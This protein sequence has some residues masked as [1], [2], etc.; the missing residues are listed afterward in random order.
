MSD[1]RAVARTLLRRQPHTYAEQAGIRLS[2]QPA[3]LYQLLV[4]ATLLSTRIRAQVAVA[5]ARE[6][7]AAGLRTPQRMEAAA[8]QDRVDALGRGHYRR[9]DERTAT[10]LGTGARLCLDRWRGDLRRLHAAAGDPA[11]LRRLLTAFPGIGPTGADIFLREVQTVWADVRP[12]ADRRALAGAARLGLP[13]SARDLAA[14]V[15]PADV[16]RLTSALV[17]V[18]LGAESAAEVTRAAADGR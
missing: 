3:A 6:L 7:F 14:L 9:Y 10:M 1:E 2:D 12:F 15:A 5:A 11:G 13:G 16:G 17:R 8:W 18:A 4:L